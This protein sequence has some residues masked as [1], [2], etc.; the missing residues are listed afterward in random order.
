MNVAHEKENIHV[1]SPK[2][3]EIAFNMTNDTWERLISV[4]DLK[5]VDKNML[6]DFFLVVSGLYAFTDGV[7]NDTKGIR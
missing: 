7:N 5:Q 3:L 6:C 2:E 4:L 1:T